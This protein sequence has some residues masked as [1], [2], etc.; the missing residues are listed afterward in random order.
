MSQEEGI[1]APE[2]ARDYDNVVSAM[3]GRDE[4]PL[5]VLLEGL[6]PLQFFNN[7]ENGYGVIIPGTN[8]AFVATETQSGRVGAIQKLLEG[9]KVGNEKRISETPQLSSV[10]G[11]IPSDAREGVWK[12]VNEVIEQVRVTAEHL[13]YGGMPEA[14]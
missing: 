7:G 3:C 1:S 14:A 6:F 10:G 11:E 9:V 5:G 2:T 12:F 4:V 8:L 13:E